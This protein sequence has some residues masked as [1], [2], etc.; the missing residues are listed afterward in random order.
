MMERSCLRSYLM[1][2]D[3]HRCQGR[4]YT[5]SQESDEQMEVDFQTKWFVQVHKCDSSRHSA[6]SFYIMD[7]INRDI[8]GG[9]T[10]STH[11]LF[12]MYFK[13]SRTVFSTRLYPSLFSPTDTQHQ[14][15]F[16]FLTEFVEKFVHCLCCQVMLFSHYAP[17]TLHT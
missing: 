3:Y 4:K 9:M 10:I 1:A 5:S 16:V 14:D 17:L 2:V 13:Q 11:S 7:H 8:L 12:D 15:A 6:I